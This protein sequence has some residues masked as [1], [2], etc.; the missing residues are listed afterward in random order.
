[1]R[2]RE[3]FEVETLEGTMR[4]DA[5]DYLAVGHE[6]DAWP[7]KADIFLATYRAVN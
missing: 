2:M 4:G 7:I 5:G 3:P 1:M 6:G